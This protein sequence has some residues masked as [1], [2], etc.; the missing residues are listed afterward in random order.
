MI[1]PAVPD[2]IPI[3]GAASPLGIRL[4]RLAQIAVELG[5]TALASDARAERERLV[6]ARF[7]VACLGQFKRG[8]STLL[9]AL[10]GDAIL[11]VGVVPVT[12][13]V[14]ILRYGASPAATVHFADERTESIAIGTIATFIDERQNRGN[15]RQAAIVDVALPSPILR[16]GL[17]LVDTPGLGSVHAAN[18]ESTRAFVPRTDVALVVVGPDPPISGAELQLIQEVSREA[19]ELIVVLNKA[20]QSTAEQLREVIEFTRTTVE[21]ALTRSI[22]RI[23]EISALERLTQAHSTRDW[24]ELETRL[25]QLS[26]TARERLVDT[27]GRRAVGRLSRRLDVELTHGDDALRRPIA[28][29]EARVTRL[30]SAVDDL[31]RSLLD[32]RFLF[33]AVEAD[34]GTQ[35]EQIRTK[36]FSGTLSK[37]QTLLEDWIAVHGSAGPSLRRQAMEEAHRLSVQSVDEWLATIEPAA[38]ALYRTAT[39]R[40]VRL[41]N[42]YISRV[43]TDGA[44]LDAGDLPLELG[45]RAR[46]QFYFTS[47]MHVTAVSPLTWLVD[48]LA[49]RSI[50]QTHVVRAAVAYLTHLLES[51]SHRVENDLK[52]RTRESRRWLEGQVRTRLAGALDSAE[53][54]VA[55]ATDKQHMSELQITERLQRV[56][57]LREEL[58]AV[59]GQ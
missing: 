52:D 7:F 1:D 9:N 28:E 37:L 45:F 50:R 42:E 48:R 39:D 27:A 22:S 51:N 56:R 49:P 12:S 5:D 13:V 17:C 58:A 29:I 36:F 2:T 6:E 57:A 41:A 26:S 25:T 24:Q 54:A 33:D 44:E 10:V 40:F 21:E 4:E 55:V 31:D 18:T 23:L 3:V 32:L 30:R 35:F 46:R 47:L 53:R 20:D 16:D 11:P 8:K 43:A 34:L 14:T 19:G 59:M 15:R 38:G